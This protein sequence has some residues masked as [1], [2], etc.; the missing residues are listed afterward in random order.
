MRPTRLVCCCAFIFVLPLGGADLQE[1]LVRA[2]AV[3]HSDW[4]ADPDYAYV[5][6]DE[7]QKDGKPASKTSQVVMMDGSE[8]SMPLSVNGQPLTP[9]QQKAELEKLKSEFERRTHESASARRQ[10][11]R[12]I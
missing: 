9:E 5:E 11:N 10:R 3:I 8:Y 1:I 6:R 4:A 2:N 7:Y 12:K